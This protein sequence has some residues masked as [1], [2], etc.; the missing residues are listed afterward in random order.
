MFGAFSAAVFYGIGTKFQQ[1]QA[2][3]GADFKGVFGTGLTGDQFANKV[4]SH[5]VAG[6]VMSRLQGGKFGHGFLSAG[7]AE[8]TA[9]MIDGIGGGAVKA[10]PA[11][12]A[13]AALVGGTVSELTGG[14]FGN[15]AMQAAFSRAFNE[16]LHQRHGAWP[17]DNQ[18]DPNE[19]SYHRYTEANKICDT[20]QGGCTV[21][22]VG[23]LMLDGFNA[24]SFGL[25]PQAAAA[26]G[27]ERLLWASHVPGANLPG[28]YTLPGGIITQ[29]ID[30]R[31]YMATNITTPKHPLYPGLINRMI[32]E[33]GGSV[34]S[35]T[36]GVGYNRYIGRPGAMLNNGVGPLMFRDQDRALQR[37]WR[38]AYGN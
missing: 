35:V 4:L 22:N 33:S 2:A 20:S 24:P 13:A 9:P 1:I 10:A 31:I 28:T 34:W 30:S 32:V 37:A 15:G 16:E 27:V 25:L 14:K 7:V 38:R 19:P 29:Q 17:A 5:G 26:P 12:V 36:H 18:F 23:G 6:G 21:E 11:R 8:L 3:N